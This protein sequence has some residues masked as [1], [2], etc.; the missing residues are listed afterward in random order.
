MNQHRP[1][2]ALISGS[3]SPHSKSRALLELAGERLDAAGFAT[4]TIDLAALPADAL[5]GRKKDARVE[6]A[7]VAVGAADV[8]VA[9]SPVYRATFSGL[10][11]VFFDLLPRNGLE[12]KIGVP[13]LTGA[14]PDH[15]LAL[16]HGFRPLF[17]SVGAVVV[18][19][20]VYGW[21][22]QFTPAPAAGLAALV[23]RAID[24]AVASART[25]V[26]QGEV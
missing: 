9:S 18:A 24:E 8:V 10:L 6:E 7:L 15:R 11:K 16:D 12:G 19:N 17:A 14:S 26:L 22:A 21:D 25:T 20:G 5:L 4:T 13:I 1:R 2:A 23:G 3:P